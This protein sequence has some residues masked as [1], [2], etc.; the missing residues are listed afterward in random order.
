MPDESRRWDP[1]A[2]AQWLEMTTLL[3]GYILA[4]QG[5]RMLMANSVEGR[6]PFL[7]PNV[8]D[9]AGSL[10]ARHK[11]FGLEEEF[12][13]K[14]GFADLIPPQVLNRP[15][16]PYRSPDA[17]AFLGPHEPSWLPEVLSASSL[18]RVGVF[19]PGKVGHLLA[20]GRRTAGEGMG[21]TDNMRVLA[22]VSTQLCFEQFVAGGGGMPSGAPLLP[23]GP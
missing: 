7:D 9:L 10:P 1:L 20:K 8:V 3:A 19:D 16:Q 14:R 17:S 11:L 21:N 4:S 5:D 12:V 22:V 18:E 13:L 23:R 2:R 15:K 6:F